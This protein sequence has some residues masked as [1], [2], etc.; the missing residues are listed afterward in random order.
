MCGGPSRM[1]GG[2]DAWTASCL[3]LLAILGA[4][5]FSS[6]AC[7]REQ[8]EKGYVAV[9]GRIP[10]GLLDQYVHPLLP[11]HR[12]EWVVVVVRCLSRVTQLHIH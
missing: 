2:A 7:S 1:R 8:E 12:L 5:A 11:R 6:P 9:D 4:V 10:I 3:L